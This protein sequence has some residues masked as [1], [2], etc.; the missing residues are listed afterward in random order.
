MNRRR[1]LQFLGIAPVAAVAA[2]YLPEQTCFK[3]TLK[4]RHECRFSTHDGIH[5]RNGITVSR[6]QP[7]TAYK[8]GDKVKV[9]MGGKAE[10]YTVVSAGITGNTEDWSHYGVDNVKIYESGTARLM[11]HPQFVLGG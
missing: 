1:F 11:N 9:F 6:W 10:V 7:S 4:G 8:V 3:G 5:P 2:K